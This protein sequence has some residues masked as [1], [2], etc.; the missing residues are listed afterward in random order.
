LF[1]LHWWSAIDRSLVFSFEQERDE[2]QLSTAQWDFWCH[3]G[4]VRIIHTKLF[5][6]F[7]HLKSLPT[8]CV[9]IK[10]NVNVYPPVKWMRWRRNAICCLATVVL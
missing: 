10:G 6:N 1:A 7:H 9:L 5:L 4:T 2:T 8:F 3:C